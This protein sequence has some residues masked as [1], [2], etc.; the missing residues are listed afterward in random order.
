MRP[1][2]QREKGRGLRGTGAR[3]DLRGRG[4]R[5]EVSGAGGQST[6]VGAHRAPQGH[7]AGVPCIIAEGPAL[8]T[9]ILLVY[10]KRV[11]VIGH[12]TVHVPPKW[13]GYCNVRTAM[14]RKEVVCA[15][16]MAPVCGCAPG[17]AP[18]YRAVTL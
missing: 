15:L 14:C 7:E 8:F 11:R 2:E 18:Q 1:E 12:T 10:H 13:S 4:T 5:D 6:G 9:P 16:A 3:D 17:L